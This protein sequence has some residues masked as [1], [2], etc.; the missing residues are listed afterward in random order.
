MGV[1]T[2]IFLQSLQ[3]ILMNV[4]AYVPCCKKI[5]YSKEIYCTS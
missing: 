4:Q 3:S 1:Y 5:Y 2:P